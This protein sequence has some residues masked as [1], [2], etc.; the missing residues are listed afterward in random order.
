M[1]YSPVSSIWLIDLSILL[2]ENRKE[3]QILTC[4]TLYSSRR[5]QKII[6]T[7]I[8]FVG[9]SNTLSHNP[10]PFRGGI[11]FQRLWWCKHINDYEIF[12]AEFNTGNKQ[13]NANSTEVPSEESNESLELDKS[14]Q[15]IKTVFKQLF[16]CALLEYV[17]LLKFSKECCATQSFHNSFYVV[18][19]QFNN[20]HSFLM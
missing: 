8:R 19:S 13:N 12:S 17:L 9:K 15:N 3:S 2:G 5:M 1:Y 14:G 16:K 10:S 20:E 7:K 4:Q 11:N 18:L 6:K